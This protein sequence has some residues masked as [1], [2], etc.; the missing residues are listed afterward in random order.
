MHFGTYFMV[1][2]GVLLEV[3][4]LL[5]GVLHHIINVILPCPICCV[6]IYICTKEGKGSK[7]LAN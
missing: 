6:V 5:H 1:S 3:P 7:M 4:R 2:T